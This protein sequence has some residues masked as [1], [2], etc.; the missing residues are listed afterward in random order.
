MKAIACKNVS[1]V[2][3]NHEVLK[4][5]DLEVETGGWTTIVGP[6]GAGKSTLIRASGGIIESSGTIKIVDKNVEELNHRQ[7]AKYVA[8][9]SQKPIIPMGMRVMDY[10]LLGRISHLGFFESEGEQDIRSAVLALKS[11][12][13]LHLVDRFVGTLSG[14]EKQRVVVA[15]ALAQDCPVLLLDEPTTALDMGHQ[16]ETLELINQLRFDRNL[17]VLSTMHDLTLA[18]RYSEHLA[19]L[20]EGKIVAEGSA[21]EVLTESLVSSHYGARVKI[22]EDK[23]GPIVVPLPK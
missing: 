7:L 11:L 21:E 2:L 3:G 16:Q 23:D 18:G 15:R 13:A 17:T 8:V 9:V 4:G 20:V 14:G 12:D 6:N 1:V 22:I 5:I 10:V 19:M